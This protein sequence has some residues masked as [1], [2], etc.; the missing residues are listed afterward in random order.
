MKRTLC[1]FLVILS[2]VLAYAQGMSDDQKELLGNIKTEISRIG[3]NDISIV[4]EI[5]C[6]QKDSLDYFV[7]V[8]NYGETRQR[9]FLIVM[10]SEIYYG[11]KEAV[12]KENVA[13][14][15]PELNKNLHRVKLLLDDESLFVQSEM[16]SNNALVIERMLSDISKASAYLLSNDFSDRVLVTKEREMRQ[17]FESSIGEV[18][19]LKIPSKC[20]EIGDSVYFKM[21]L[22]KDYHSPEGEVRDF[23]IGETEVVQKLWVAM[24]G[25]NPSY[26][27][28]GKISNKEDYPVE[29]VSFEDIVIFLDS[30]N[31][32]FYRQGYRFRVPTKDEWLY[33][34]QGGNES[35]NY[36]Y[37]GNNMLEKVCSFPICDEYG[38]YLL[39]PVKVKSR[40]PNEL[41]IYD[42]SGNVAEICVVGSDEIAAYG[43][44]INF[45]SVKDID[46]LPYFK[47]K[48][49]EAAS[50]PVTRNEHNTY[51]GFRLVMDKINID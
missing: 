7:S 20:S 1:T 42:M 46:D 50:L 51:Y 45:L 30:L 8:E 9:P 43:G 6:F 23:W 10:Y 29:S 16:S 2:S 41:K 36:T 37:S 31:A 17:E 13:K 19:T 26:Y 28:K 49:D 33:A 35:E 15:L 21:I 40:K 4:D 22:V 38:H 12:T 39:G 44:S 5:L 47:V 48:V 14:L 18:Q 34:A 27:N 32:C 3:V 25:N 24:M 11:K